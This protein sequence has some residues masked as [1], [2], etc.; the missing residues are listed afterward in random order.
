MTTEQF[1][2]IPQRIT[3]Q[4]AVAANGCWVWCGLKDRDG[5]GVTRESPVKQG[6]VHRVVWKI[7]NG[8]IPPGL[9][10]DHLCCQRDCCNPEHLR[11]CTHRENLF[12][13]HSLSTPKRF[14]EKTHCPKGHPYDEINTYRHA[15]GR[16]CRTCQHERYLAKR[17]RACQGS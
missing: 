7:F 16:M 15:R 6:R 8:D 14:A 13:A 5:Y 3:R 17:N 2:K 12:A 4:I 10:I 11:V 9:V 1:S